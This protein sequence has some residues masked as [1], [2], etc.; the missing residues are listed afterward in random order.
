MEGA[1]EIAGAI[2]PGYVKH[3]A[4]EVARLRGPVGLNLGGRTPPE[5]AMSVV[6]E[7]TAVRR[8]AHNPPLNDGRIYR[9]HPG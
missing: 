1:V 3:V 7:M 2:Q 4:E 9:S 8:G 5:I 6:A